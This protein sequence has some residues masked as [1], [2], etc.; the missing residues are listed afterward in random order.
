MTAYK[1]KLHETVEDTGT[2]KVGKVMGFEGPYVQLRP[3]GGGREWDAKQENLKP[4][5]VSDGLSAAVAAANAQS[6]GEL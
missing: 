2:R 3:I 1:P 5:T 4:V 6:R